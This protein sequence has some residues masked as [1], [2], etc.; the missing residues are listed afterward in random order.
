M[1]IQVTTNKNAVRQLIVDMRDAADGAF[2]RVVDVLDDSGP[3]F[4]RSA[5]RFAP[6]DTGSLR[7]RIYY[8]VFTSSRN[9][10]MR[11]GPMNSS[12]DR[13]AGDKNAIAYAGYVHD[14]TSRVGPRPFMDQAVAKHTTD[15]GKLM[16]GLRK[17]GVANLGRSTGGI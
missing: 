16:R 13:R 10:R 1:P 3:T 7:R 8:K 11:L 14:G 9:P 12:P 5:R 2:D 4:V 15:Q 17:A 6:I